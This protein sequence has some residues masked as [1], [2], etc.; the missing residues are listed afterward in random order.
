MAEAKITQHPVGQG[1][2]CAGSVSFNKETIRWV[3]DCGSKQGDSLKR[4]I[5][6]LGKESLDLLFISH[7]HNDHINGIELLLGVRD[8]TEVV[9]P[10]LTEYERL[11]ILA[12]QQDR[13]QLTENF[14]S[15][16]ENPKKWFSAR[17]VKNVTFVKSSRDENGGKGEIEFRRP[18]EDIR[19][20]LT[21]KWSKDPEEIKSGWAKGGRTVEPNAYITLANQNGDI[22]DWVFIPQ[23]HPIDP[24][25]TSAFQTA[26]IEIFLN[27]DP[28]D[29]FKKIIKTTVL[30]DKREAMHLFYKALRK[31]YKKLWNDQNEVTMSLYSGGISKDTRWYARFNYYQGIYLRNGKS[32]DEISGWLCTGDTD[33][34]SPQRRTAFLTFYEKLLENIIVFVVPHHGSA[35]NF[36]QE[37][38]D[39]MPNLICGVASAGCNGYGHPNKKVIEAIESCAD[40]VLVNKHAKTKFTLKLTS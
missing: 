10:Y 23:V 14:R 9:L 33:L 31:A 28:I 20:E 17:G 13:G 39:R 32:K 37:L 35:K 34:S 27:Q 18:S 12:E 1:G 4:E 15:F 8:T 40:F 2:L 6:F 36:H 11:L 7:F 5:N 16:I 22:A 21:P 24:N 29:S 19:G 38:L 30:K 25:Q 3:Y 26:L